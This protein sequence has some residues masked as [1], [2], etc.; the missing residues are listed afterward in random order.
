M[1]VEI[2]FKRE[3]NWMFKQGPSQEFQL[4]LGEQFITQIR[5]IISV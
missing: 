4:N 3:K 5:L 1:Q 2:G